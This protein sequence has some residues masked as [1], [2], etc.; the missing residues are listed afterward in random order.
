MVSSV[1]KTDAALQ[2]DV[3]DALDFDPR[4]TASHIG[5][6]VR[7]GIVTLTG[8]V[9][10]YTERYDAGMVTLGVHGVR[11]LADELEVDLPFD[12]HRDDEDVAR[13]I[14]RAL[15]ANVLVPDEHVKVK[16]HGGSV[17]LSG[18]VD[19]NY[20]RQA[21]EQT[22]RVTTG[23]TG[24]VDLITIRP[25]PQASWTEVK[26]KIDSSFQRHASLDAK[27]VKVAVDG[28]AVTL[29]G[30]VRS[31]AEWRDAEEAA[32]SAPGVHSVKNQIELHFGN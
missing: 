4:I 21:A 8:K 22:A 23:V 3:L 17:T 6:S 18:E 20:Q 29:T 15:D 11:A 14:T 26:K 24:V 28:G 9:R 10:T 19:W 5:V 31:M 7:D 27:K 13:A 2:Q 32:W 12:H 30:A 1:I 25:R 16:V